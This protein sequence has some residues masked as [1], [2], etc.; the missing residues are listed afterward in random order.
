VVMDVDQLGLVL[1]HFSLHCKKTVNFDLDG[2]IGTTTCTT[3]YYGL[4]FL[5]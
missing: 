1:L 2:V 4:D 3:D 5:L